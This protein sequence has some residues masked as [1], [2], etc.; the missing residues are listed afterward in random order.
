MAGVEVEID[1]N[2]RV[3]PVGFES[4]ECRVATQVD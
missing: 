2:S 3:Y 4:V 1:L